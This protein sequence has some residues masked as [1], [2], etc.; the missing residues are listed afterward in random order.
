VPGLSFYFTLYKKLQVLGHVPAGS[1]HGAGVGGFNLNNPHAVFGSSDAGALLAPSNTPADSPLW[2]VLNS[3]AMGNDGFTTVLVNGA[4]WP[5]MPAGT[6]TSPASWAEFQINA[7]APKLVTV[8]GDWIVAGKIDDVPDDVLSQ[9]PATMR[10]PSSGVVPFACNMPGDDG[11]APVPSNYWATSLVF[12]VDPGTGNTVAPS[13][14]AAGTEYFLA[15][16]L[17]N[18]GNERGGR[19]GTSGGVTIESDAHVMVWNTGMSPAVKLPALSNLD[20]GSSAPVYESYFMPAGGYDVVGFRL[21]VQTVFDGLVKAVAESEV[22]LGGLSAAEWVLNHPAHL[23]ARVRVR[24]VDQGWPSLSDPP[25]TERRLAQK[26]LA[27]F[28]VDLTVQD[29]DPDIEWHN[30]L[31]G[32]ALRLWRFHRDWGA[33]RLTVSTTLRRDQADIYLAI[34]TATFERIDAP[35]IDGFEPQDV[36]GPFPDGVVLRYRFEENALPLPRLG[37]GQFVALSLGIRPR[38]SRIRPGLAGHVSV[39]QQAVLPRV[40]G[41]RDCFENE[42]QVTGGFTIAVHATVSEWRGRPVQVAADP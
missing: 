1:N 7:P 26:N 40:E 16:V 27:P 3:R 10:R 36:A 17:G 6:G 4:P 19:Y 21:P 5:T 24:R 41:G 23:C 30:F 25:T 31:A 22:D 20:A 11:V 15:A 33:I 29:P 13:H 9:V 32:D 8:L 42:W 38:R 28:A 35:A 37:E 2:A 12:L 18:R 34:P 39:V 14:L